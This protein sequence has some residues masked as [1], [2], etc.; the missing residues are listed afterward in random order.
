[1]KKFLFRSF[2]KKLDMSIYSCPMMCC[3]LMKLIILQ[4]FTN[5][6]RSTS[7]QAGLSFSDLTRK[8]NNFHLLNC[9]IR[10][11]TSSR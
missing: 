2:L 1:M 8:L 11:S 3:D 10:K 7:R 9:F 5:I 4:S 6:C